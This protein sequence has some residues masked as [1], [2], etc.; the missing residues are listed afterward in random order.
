MRGW[1]A[2]LCAVFGDGGYEDECMESWELGFVGLQWHNALSIG[3]I[4]RAAF[5]GCMM[6]FRGL[7]SS[8]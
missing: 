6:W 7:R 2:N 4:A 8:E 3:S 5:T 1:K